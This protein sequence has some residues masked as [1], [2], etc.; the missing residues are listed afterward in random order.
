SLQKKIRKDSELLSGEFTDLEQPSGHRD[1][2]L[3][4]DECA[5]QLQSARQTLHGRI[6][7]LRNQTKVLEDKLERA[8]AL[9]QDLER[10]QKKMAI[11][12]TLA[13]ALRGDEFIAFIQQEAYRRLAGDGSVHLKLLSSD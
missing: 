13:Q 3:Q 12:R 1:E 9:R 11:A 6:I 4:L 2:A 5:R 7:D 8:A 10:N